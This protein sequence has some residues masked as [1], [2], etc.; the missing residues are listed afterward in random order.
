MQ[1]IDTFCFMMW[2][3]PEWGR[4]E[5]SARKNTV[6]PLQDIQGKR[7]RGLIIP[8]SL[9]R[10]H[11]ETWNQQQ[12]M[13]LRW[14]HSGVHYTGDMASFSYKDTGLCSLANSYLETG[15]RMNENIK[16]LC[17]ITE[18]YSGTL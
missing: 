17:Q 6:S 2:H 3:P 11:P 15:Y 1:A 8:L 13:V 10:R 5:K 7:T 18:D 12:E 4:V 9:P 14:A 16:F